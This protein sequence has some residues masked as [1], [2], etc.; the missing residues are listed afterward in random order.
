MSNMAVDCFE[1][2][3]GRFSGALIGA[4]SVGHFTPA[5]QGLTLQ[6]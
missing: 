5:P 4:N 2:T 6:I 1:K 3:E